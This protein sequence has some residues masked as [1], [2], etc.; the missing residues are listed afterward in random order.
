MLRGRSAQEPLRPTVGGAVTARH[1]HRR[2]ASVFRRLAARSWRSKI[3]LLR[4]PAGRFSPSL[5]PAAENRP[6]SIRP[7]WARSG[8][9]QPSAIDG[10]RCAAAPGDRHGNFQEIDLSW[11]TTVENVAFPLRRPGCQG[12]RR[13]R[14]RALIKLVG[15]DG[16]R[17]ATRQAV[18]RHRQRTAIART[19]AFRPKIS[20]G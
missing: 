20:Y 7:E 3:S 12:G 16:S 6:Y 18:R 8:R 15:L 10:G 5:A 11:R 4:R 2:V 19:L 1:W 14:A 17:T 13:A 9:S